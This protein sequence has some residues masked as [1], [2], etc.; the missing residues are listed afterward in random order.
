MKKS[1]VKRP[2]LAFKTL[3]KCDDYATRLAMG[4]LFIRGLIYDYSSD[5]NGNPTAHYSATLYTAP[6]AADVLHDSDDATAWREVCETGKR[7]QQIGYGNRGDES[8]LYSLEKLGYSVDVA[9]TD[10]N[11]PGDRSVVVYRVESVQ[12]TTDRSAGVRLKVDGVICSVVRV[13]LRKGG[14]HVIVFMDHPHQPGVVCSHHT[15]DAI[16]WKRFKTGSVGSV[17]SSF[18]LSFELVQGATK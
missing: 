2:A 5:S 18:G 4:S 11:R 16:A 12:D 10:I 6:T 14:S 8:L 3:V 15:F 1:T 7:R 17:I 9:A 13:D